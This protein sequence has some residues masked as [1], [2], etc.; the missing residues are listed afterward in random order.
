ML[1]Q[2]LASIKRPGGRREG[3]QRGKVKLFF[4]FLATPGGVSGSAC[5]S[6]MAPV[7]SG[8]CCYCLRLAAHH[9]CSSHRMSS[10]TFCC[11]QALLCIT[12]LSFKNSKSSSSI[13]ELVPCI[14]FLLFTWSRYYF[15]EK[16]KII[17]NCN[18]LIIVYKIIH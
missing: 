15:Q 10:A 14:K 3:G 4:P 2:C 18:N 5:V 8:S 16:K 1:L 6:L 17:S 13:S 12:F 11:S 7:P 9:S